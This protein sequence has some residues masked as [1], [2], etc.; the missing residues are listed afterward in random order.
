MPTEPQ[1]QVQRIKSPRG[2]G[3]V[4]NLGNKRSMDTN[5]HLDNVR[6]H[7]DEPARE[8]QF[9]P[10]ILSEELPGHFGLRIFEYIG[11][12]DPWDHMCRFMEK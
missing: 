7:L 10:S 6:R 3:V 1:A 11:K 2:D 4:D 12:A 5:E 9:V 8:K